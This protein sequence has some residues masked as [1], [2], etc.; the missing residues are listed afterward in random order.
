M[1]NIIYNSVVIGI[2]YY[3]DNEITKHMLKAP[4]PY[5]GGKSTVSD[6]VWQ[7]FGDVGN[8]IEP[9][10]GSL[11]VLL[12]RPTEPRVETVNDADCFLANFWRAL[13]KEPEEVAKFADWPV[14]ECDLYARHKWLVS[15]VEF[16]EKMENDPE[17]YDAKI[18]GWWVWGLSQ[19]IGSGWCKDTI[20]K[21]RPHL[22]NAG[23]GIH[24]QS[25]VV[26]QKPQLSHSMG[27]HRQFWVVRQRHKLGDAG[28]G[29]HR[30]SLY[31][32][33]TNQLIDYFEQLANRLRRVRVCCGDW[34]RVLT[35]AVTTGNGIA[36]I[37]LDPPYCSNDRSNDLYSIDSMTI[38]NDVRKWAIENGDNKL[39]R[40]ALCGY[41]N[42]YDMP[43]NWIKIAWKANGGYE[44]Q[45]N[46]KGNA[47]KERIW[48]SPYCIGKKQMNLFGLV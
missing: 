12:G 44:N 38:A 45:G 27:I 11:A 18:A 3:R 21:K 19:W 17:Y 30:S 15:R 32:N 35:R 25:L 9:F 33:N 28:N 22:G 13:S 10:A 4:F 23:M 8:Y 29:I 42:D 16:K 39:F 46:G 36:G 48:F 1:V 5:F 6:I 7:N 43:K 26:R 31:T 47:G 20:D 34:T 2:V 40:I 14:N 41:E 37:F 24:K